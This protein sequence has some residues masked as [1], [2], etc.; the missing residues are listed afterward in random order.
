MSHAPAISCRGLKKYYA[1]VKAVDGLDLEVLPGECFGLL[2]PNGAGKT[3]TIEILEGLTK[4]DAGE[5]TVLGRRWG[6]QERELRE[7]LGVSLQESRLTEKLTVYETLELFRSF[8]ERGREPEQ[9]LQDMSLEEKRDAR[10][11]KLS[12]GQRQRLAV[13]CALAGD[14][15]LLF[16]DEP[17]TGLDPQSRLQ[18]WE[19]IARFKALGRTV[20]LTTHYMEE[21]ERLCDRVAVVDHGRIIAQGS[22]AELIAGLKAPHFIE[23]AS[24]PPVADDL[25]AAI[26][27]IGER[28]LRDGRWLLAAPNLA[29]AV[30]ALLEALERAGARL[31]SLSTHRSTLE[32]VFI[33]LT[34][35]ELRDE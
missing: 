35:R 14:P 20:L 18:L 2:G 16:L 5:V 24:E 6:S 19:R 22:P 30:P 15:E 13:A 26:P 28:R 3:T 7:R 27:G 25:L 29:Q 23:F 10:V 17:T 34:G 9:L 12:G 11:G 33:A 21:A 31:L 32:D 8:Y 1:D 4:P